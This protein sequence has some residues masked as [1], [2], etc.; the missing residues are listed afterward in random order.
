MIYHPK[1]EDTLHLLQKQM[2]ETVERWHLECAFASDI[3]HLQTNTTR[4]WQLCQ[5]DVWQL[6]NQ[7]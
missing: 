1:A 3:L 5:P 7:D 6:W 4:V 2:E